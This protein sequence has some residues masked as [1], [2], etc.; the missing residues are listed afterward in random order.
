MDSTNGTRG[1]LSVTLDALRSGPLRRALLAYL[2][3]NIV[4]WA[5]WIAILVWAFQ[6]GGVRSSSLIAVAQLVPA[7]LLAPFVAAWSSRR[8]PRTALVTG[9]LAQGTTFAT[10][11]VAL[12]VGAPYAVCAILAA[13]A[14]VAVT[15]SRPVHNA[16]LPAISR[17]TGELTVGNAASGSVEALA[18][19]L[20]PVACAALIGPLGA[21]GVV[22]VMGFCSLAAAGLTV[23]LATEAG[24]ASPSGREPGALQ[25]FRAIAMHP[26]ARAITSLVAVEQVVVGTMDILLVLLAI[27]LL[28]MD[29]SGPA[30]LNSVFGVG[31]LLGSAAAVVLIAGRRIVTGLIAAA[32]VCGAAL[33]ATSLTSGAWTAAAA[34]VVSGAGKVYFDIA[35]RTLL[36]RALPERLLIAV[37]GAMEAV[38]MGGIAIGSVIVPFLV[39]AAGPRGAFV[40][41]GLLL[42]L[43]ALVTA[44][45]LSR[46]DGSVRVPADVLALLTGVPI[47]TVLAPRLLDRLALE[48]KPGSVAAGTVVVREGDPAETFYVIRSG[49]AGVSI[50]GRRVRDLGPG[51]W[52]G[53]LA[54]LHDTPRTA[55][56]TATTVLD[57]LMLERDTFLSLVAGVPHAVQEAD[58]YARRTYE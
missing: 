37:F 39:L 29:E 56:I 5:T 13:L 7:A 31:G 54:L 46:L 50:G 14:A 41:A 32:V 8:R 42:P 33:A 23:G 26:G 58:D 16:L 15:S 22:L 38:T 44:R 52:F 9:Y 24:G 53:E 35:L 18:I 19:L 30:L 6:E 21:G 48:A 47:L 4:E 28:A 3:F 43:G 20:G 11:G 40:V 55:T 34:L 25:Q 17:T 1:R 2:I 10:T 27:D 51:A 36:Q 49:T 45:R 12:A 57:V